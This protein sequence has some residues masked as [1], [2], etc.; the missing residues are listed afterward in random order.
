MTG[1][2]WLIF[3]HYLSVKP[4]TP[5][6]VAA[7][8]KINTTMVWIRIPGLGLQF[9]KK[10]ILMTMAKGVDTHIKVD[11]NTVD[12]HKGRFARICVE[13]DLDQPVVGRIRLRGTWYNVEYE[14]FHL[15]CARCGC[16]GNMS[17]NCETPAPSVV[18][19]ESTTLGIATA[20]TANQVPPIHAT[21]QETLAPS[22]SESVAPPN[23]SGGNQGGI[24]AGDKSPELAHGE[25]LTVTRK[26]R[27][28]Q[29]SNNERAHNIQKE[30]KSLAPPVFSFG[31][32]PSQLPNRKRPRNVGV[33]QA[34][35]VKNNVR[36]T[37]Q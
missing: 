27:P 24:K 4:W 30:R 10:N 5:D 22:P 3:D 34:G 31:A 26:K 20:A 17:R 16:Y 33:G 21:T 14:G 37:K 23:P 11:L 7:N 12:M 29:G 25:W 15:L 19:P 2:P 6:F 13:I 1:A 9:Y 36:P 8:S 35:V 32:D 28:S 18:R